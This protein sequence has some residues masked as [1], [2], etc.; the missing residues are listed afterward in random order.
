MKMKLKIRA[1][2]ALHNAIAAVRARAPDDK[3]MGSISR[4]F[5]YALSR[6]A[7]YI[8]PVADAIIEM[9]KPSPEFLEFDKKRM[10]L[11]TICARKDE[12]GIPILQN[13]HFQIENLPHFEK[14]LSLLRTEYEFPVSLWEKQRVE[15]QAKLEEEE[16]IEIYK[17]DFD[18]LPNPCPLNIMEALEPMLKPVG[19]G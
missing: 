16:E 10:D 13:G 19:A 7:A 11:A 1:I 3:N 4:D 8:K 15:V 5:S 9:E 18:L 12:A 14:E 6:T 2:V 17:V